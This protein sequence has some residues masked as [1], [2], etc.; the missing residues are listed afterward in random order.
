MPLI[1]RNVVRIGIGGKGTMN[2]EKLVQE[3]PGLP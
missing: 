2:P 1:E 3:A